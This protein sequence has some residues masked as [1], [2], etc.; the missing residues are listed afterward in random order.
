MTAGG[1]VRGRNVWPHGVSAHHSSDIETWHTHIP[2]TLALHLLLAAPSH[3]CMHVPGC[4]TGRPRQRLLPPSQRHSHRDL[5]RTLCLPTNLYSPHR[6]QKL[7]S[8]VTPLLSDTGP[9]E[10]V[11]AASASLYEQRMEVL[12]EAADCSS[13]EVCSS[14]GSIGGR[15][16]PGAAPRDFRGGARRSRTF[17]V[18]ERYGWRAT[19]SLVFY[20]ILFGSEFRQNSVRSRENSF[21]RQNSEFIRNS[22]I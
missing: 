13:S 2:S 22:E 8:T 1:A 20:P 19:V 11:D 18:F 21:T 14:P 4:R 17:P 3:L 12:I 10:V 7:W 6:P 16:I 9:A 5:R 15:R